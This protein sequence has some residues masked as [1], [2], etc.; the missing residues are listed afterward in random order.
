MTSQKPGWTGLSPLSRN[1]ISLHEQ[2]QYLTFSLE[3][4]WGEEG[5]ALGAITSAEVSV[6]SIETVAHL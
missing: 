2:C 3:A 1:N 4:A 5:S 6:K